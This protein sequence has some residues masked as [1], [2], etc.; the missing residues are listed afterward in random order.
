MN[1]LYKFC[2][3]YEHLLNDIDE[4]IQLVKDNNKQVEELLHSFDELNNDTDDEGE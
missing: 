1:E 2:D 3:N 4:L